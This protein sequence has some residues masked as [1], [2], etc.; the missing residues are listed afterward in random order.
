MEKINQLV[1]I[2]Y[3][4]QKRKLRARNIQDGRWCSFPNKLRV[5]NK[6]FK[7]AK[8]TKGRGDSWRASKPSEFD[9]T[10]QNSEIEEVLSL[11][12]KMIKKEFYNNIVSSNE[13][14]P[15][16]NTEMLN[17]IFIVKS[18]FPDIDEQLLKPLI[19]RY[20]HSAFIHEDL[21]VDLQNLFMNYNERR[22]IT[23]LSNYSELD[24]LEDTIRMY[25]T[26]F[27]EDILI[28]DILPKKPKKI[29]ELHDIF[30]RECS[31]IKIPN[32]SLRQD[33][34]FHLDNIQVGDCKIFVPKKTHDLIEVG[35]SLHICVG[36]GYYAKEVIKKNFNIIILLK[37]NRP[38]AC[39]QFTK[40]HIVQAKKFR[41]SN[42]ESN[43]EEIL[44]EVLFN[45]EKNVA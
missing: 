6:V 44:K 34:L 36:N 22:V 16:I 4:N 11:K 32:N 38:Y 2:V 1:E 25:K 27:E 41:N 42:L 37:D 28:D 10:N 26:L 12:N 30:M 19:K 18:I 21:I 35:N 15:K 13:S 43:T 9:L 5:K 31:K 45:K 20:T 7:A 3:D 29:R 23:L 33:S 8:I 40:N 39:I 17:I 24:F 14:I